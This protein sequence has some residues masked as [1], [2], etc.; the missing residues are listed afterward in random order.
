MKTNGQQK[1][2]MDIG[3]D[4]SQSSFEVET[5][6]LQRYQNA[7]ITKEGELCCPVDYEKADIDFLPREIVEK[8]YG[9]ITKRKQVKSCHLGE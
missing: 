3:N 6:V 1:S 4:T 5:E 7:A 2:S 8:D 9:F